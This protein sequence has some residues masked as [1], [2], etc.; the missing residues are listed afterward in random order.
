MASRRRGLLVAAV[1]ALA[2]S[3]VGAQKKE[4][5]VPTLEVSGVLAD[6]RGP[7]AKKVVRVG[8]VDAK[9]QMLIL[10]VDATK[11]RV[12][13]GRVVLQPFKPQ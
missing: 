10:K 5:T 4:A 6:A 3:D 9:G 1:L 12:D 2:A 13:V 8:P 7:L 11:G